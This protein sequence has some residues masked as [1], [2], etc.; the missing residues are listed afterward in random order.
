MCE[1]VEMPDLAG[2]KSHEKTLTLATWVRDV[3]EGHAPAT[4]RT[5]PRA[6]FR[7]SRKGRRAWLD[8]T[9][10]EL[11]RGAYSS[12]MTLDRGLPTTHEED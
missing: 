8:Q 5:P 7:D 3:V 4:P 12:H 9:G 10:R 6:A 2:L 11:K 1:H